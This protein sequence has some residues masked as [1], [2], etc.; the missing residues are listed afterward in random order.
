MV[1]YLLYRQKLLAWC[2]ENRFSK[3]QKT[4]KMKNEIFSKQERKWKITK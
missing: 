1:H 3:Y 4:G 2:V